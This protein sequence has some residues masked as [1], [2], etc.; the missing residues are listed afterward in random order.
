[1]S[2]YKAVVQGGRAVIE[3]LEYEDGTELELEVVSG[4]D[5][6][7]DMD[8]EERDRLHSAL[9]RGLAQMEA[10]DTVPAEEVIARLRSRHA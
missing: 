8:D 7:D 3:N 10:G 1:M 6:D 5:L 4:S 2:T 9:D